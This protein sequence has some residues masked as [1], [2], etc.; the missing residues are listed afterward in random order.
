MQRGVSGEIGFQRVEPF[1]LQVVHSLQ[2]LG[3][4]VG[5]IELQLRQNFL[6]KGFEL[7]ER[8]LRRQT[9]LLDFRLPLRQFF[10]T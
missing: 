7:G 6:A 3:Q 5:V 1:Q 4:G 10:A 8:F 9:R 2:E